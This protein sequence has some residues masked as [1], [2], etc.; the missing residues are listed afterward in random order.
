MDQV[1]RWLSFFVRTLTSASRRASV[2]MVT[3]I[4][5]GFLGGG[6]VGVD[7]S[8]KRI[9]RSAGPSKTTWRYARGG[10]ARVA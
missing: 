8:L 4:G 7:C 9:R 5:W 10:G 6:E 1:M 3:W 2:A